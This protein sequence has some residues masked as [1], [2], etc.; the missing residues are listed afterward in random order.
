LAWS[1]E[2]AHQ[3]HL[4][5]K[6]IVILKFDFEKAFDKVEREPMLQVMQH[7]GFPPKWL[8]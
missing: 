6:E 1:L 4:T 7:K 2:Y 8:D 3:C 5:R